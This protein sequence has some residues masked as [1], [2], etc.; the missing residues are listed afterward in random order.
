MPGTNAVGVRLESRAVLSP[1]VAVGL[2]LFAAL[3]RIPTLALR[4][5]VEG[6][7]VHYARL[8]RFVLAGDFSGLANPYWSNLWPALIA[9]TSVVTGL[10]VVAAG[11]L[12]ALVSGV[13]LVPATAALAT[14]IFGPTAGLVAGLL[15]AAH[16]WLIHFSTLVFTESFFGLLLVAFLLAV[17]SAAGSPL[18]AASAGLLGG[19]AVVTRPEAY[20]ASVAAVLWLP[21]SAAGSARGRAAARAAVVGGIIALFV[22]GRAALVHRYFGLWDFGIGNKGTANLFVGL[23]R[24]D[25]D[26]ERIATEVGP[27]GTSVLARSAEKQTLAGFALS[28]P[29]LLTR[30]IA[31]NLGR[32]AAAATRVFPFVPL[33]GG[34]HPLWSGTWPGL[35]TISASAAGTF[36][37]WGLVSAVRDPRTAR[38]AG[39]L[40]ATGTLYALGL[41]PLFVHDRLVVALVPLFVIFLA[42]GLASA[43]RPFVPVE[44]HLQWLLG[45]LLVVMGVLSLTRLFRAPT[46]DYA[47]DPVVQRETGEWL[48]ARYPQDTPIMTAAVSVGFYFYDV[49]HAHQEGTLPWA[50]VDEVIR[51]ARLQGK[52]VLV[53]PEWHLRAV[54]H[55]AAPVL[56]HP[57]RE[58]PGL[59]HAA[60]LGS[61]PSGRM[62]VYEIQPA[63][64]PAVPPP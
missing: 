4:H 9:A 12:A 63:P 64:S 3:L 29:A 24:D 51:L 33:V 55:P 62:F 43:A 49:A 22:C 34:R 5:L 7:G 10:D 26:M 23:A 13:L 54:R 16:P 39:L 48:A 46:L 58:Y 6:D 50:N 57:E 20:A 41:A 61:E 30:H 21:T 60:T 53:V 8:A 37:L 47:G 14:R 15:A 25:T 38:L 32:L 28:H 31:R 35:L 42:Q 1:R 59:R 2:V 19:L 18:A 40:L 45:T 17:L 27:D 11:R 52:R 56:L 44:R 36:A